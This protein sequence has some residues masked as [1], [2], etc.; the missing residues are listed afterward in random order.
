MKR[1]LIK[2]TPA[3]MGKFNTAVR[4]AKQQGFSRRTTEGKIVVNEIYAE[5]GGKW[6]RK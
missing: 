1:K 6:K 5:L 3:D 4:Q 2:K